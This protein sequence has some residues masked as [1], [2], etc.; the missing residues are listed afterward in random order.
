MLKVAVA[1]SGGVDSAV[2]AAILKDQGYTVAGFYMRNWSEAIDARGFCPFV[3]D[4]AMARMVASHL[5]IPFYMLD[6]EEVYKKEVIDPFF[7]DY[8]KGLTP[9][10]DVLC[11][12][13]IKFGVFLDAAKR[14]GFDNIATGHYAKIQSDGQNKILLRG[15]DPGKDQS[16][17]L[18]TLTE[19]ELEQTYMPIGE[20][21]KSQVRA[22]A[23]KYKL[24][25]AERKDSQGIC[26]IGPISVSQFLRS[27]LPIKGGQVLDENGRQ[28]GLHDGVW[29]YT[30]GQR[31]GAGVSGQRVPRY[32][33]KKDAHTNT[34]WAVPENHPWLYSNGFTVTDFSFVDGQIPEGE[35]DV[36][37]RYH[38]ETKRGIIKKEKDAT[39]KVILEEPEKA[40]TAGQSAVFYNGEKLLG[41]GVIVEAPSTKIQISKG[42]YF[43]HSLLIDL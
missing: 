17:F 43:M 21:K 8:Q 4:A 24:P 34:L 11:N 20:Y 13:Y 31:Q 7:K 12:K 6:F 5:D 23:K 9:N 2:T 18:W 1:L 22:M 38:H 26:F 40:I 42:F 25:N 39:L 37:I 16:Y 33:A 19:N 28:I 14:L 32:I 3:A 30:I 36:V 27:R 15:I 29:F 35:V 10:P 41:G